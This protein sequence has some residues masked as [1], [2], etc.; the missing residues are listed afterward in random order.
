LKINS[1]RCFA[2]FSRVGGRQQVSLVDEC[3]E[4]ATIIHEF[5][6]VIGLYVFKI[7]KNIWR[8]AKQILF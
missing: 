4:Y 5:M 3:I 1:F 8:R 6:H 2:D 7:N